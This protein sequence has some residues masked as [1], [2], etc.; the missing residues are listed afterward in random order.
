MM[1]NAFA[2]LKFIFAVA[3][4]LVISFLLCQNNFLFNFC[5]KLF[6]RAEE[7]S[8]EQTQSLLLSSPIE[9]LTYHFEIDNIEKT[10]FSNEYD[11]IERELKVVTSNGEF[12]FVWF[13]NSQELTGETEDYI[14]IKDVAQ[15]GTYS[16]RIIKSDDES[17]FTD[18]NNFVVS[19]GKKNI[20]ITS[21]TAV[22]K[23]FDGNVDI[24]VNAE[25]SGIESLDDV[26]LDVSGQCSNPNA[27]ENKFVETSINLGGEDASNY[28]VDYAPNVFVNISKK[29]V[30]I[31][32]ATTTNSTTFTYNQQNQI[33]KIKTPYYSDVENVPVGLSFSISGFKTFQSITYS[34]SNE[35]KYAGNYKATIKLTPNEINYQFNN[36]DYNL[37]MKRAETNFIFENLSFVYNGSVQDA[38]DCVRIDND[39]QT[40]SFMGQTT[41]TTV[42][43][44]NGKEISVKANE[45][46]NYIASELK[47]FSIS[48]ARA[49][50]QI[51]VTNVRTKYVYNGQTQKVNS[52]ALLNNN[53]QTLIYSNNEFKNVLDGNNRVVTIYAEKSP[54]YEFSSKS[55]TIT[56]EKANIDTSLWHWNSIKEFSYTGLEKAIYIQGYNQNLVTPY[57]SNNKFTNAG[58][59]YATVNILLKDQNNYNPVSFEGVAW[60]IKRAEIVKPNI[61]DK[62][63]TYNGQEQT[64]E[65][66]ENI[67]YNIKNNKQTNA[68]EYKVEVGLKDLVNMMWSDKTNSPI[69]ANWKINKYKIDNPT[70]SNKI[71][72]DG[73][74]KVID[75]QEN[76]IYSVVC[77]KQTN[78]GD[79]SAYLVLKD[80]ENYEWSS[81][82]D[83]YLKV[84]W[85]I[86]TIPSTSNSSILA[87]LLTTLIIC[88]VAIYITLHSTIVITRKRRKKRVVTISQN[89]SQ[90]ISENAPVSEKATTAPVVEQKVESKIKEI[91]EEKTKLIIEEKVKAPRK[92][93]T[94]SRKKID[95]KRKKIVKKKSN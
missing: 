90:N 46:L 54:N 91:K 30:N 77:D 1:K 45:S 23:A 63:S 25:Y 32:W 58:M 2:K 39:E 61:L 79:Y 57:Y 26:T 89:A 33:E 27:E 5:S 78:A 42:Q 51:D 50:S 40:L 88:L 41:F 72:F 13:F 82:N 47:Q 93:R 66:N 14:N 15:S 65:I 44:G 29:A 52:G 55:V 64:F 18:T 36:P 67:Y 84:D 35:F 53:E 7:L 74:E 87:V 68:G 20:N 69:Y 3:I 62:V 11:G 6:T 73:N 37:E 95:K 80:T 16:C 70:Y 22:D 17:Y 10:S 19:I 48:V 59:Y 92:K 43:E 8:S 21:L 71:L 94:L 49:T 9:G 4:V 34:Y 86:Y 75:L 56:V 28:K 24:E 76:N 12:D 60:E 83:N 31:I 38:R 85:E 81:S